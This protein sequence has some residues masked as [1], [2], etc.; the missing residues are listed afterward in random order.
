MV[1]QAI[2]F[3]AGRLYEQE[4]IYKLSFGRFFVSTYHYNC[5]KQPKDNLYAHVNKAASNKHDGL[6]DYQVLALINQLGRDLISVLVLTN[7][8]GRNLISVLGL[9]N[10]FS[11]YRL[12][13]VLQ[14]F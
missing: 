5:K 10:L 9:T 11:P 13:L 2:M 12:L 7:L 14:Y 8:L 6:L 1:K 3:V 4:H